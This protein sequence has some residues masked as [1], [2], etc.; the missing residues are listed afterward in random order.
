M[1]SLNNSAYTYNQPVVWNI[2]L[3]E[4][5]I[6]CIYVKIKGANGSI[7]LVTRNYHIQN[8]VLLDLHRGFFFIHLM[9]EFLF[10]NEIFGFQSD[11]PS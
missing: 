7:K 4:N 3:N 1:H 10:S 8:D 6:Y 5:L 2:I 11:F 9:T